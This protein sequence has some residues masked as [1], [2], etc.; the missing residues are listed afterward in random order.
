M[1]EAPEGLS[2]RRVMASAFCMPEPCALTP[3]W[4]E[5]ELP[6]AACVWLLLT[7]SP[8]PLIRACFLAVLEE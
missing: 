1:A 3:V 7:P 4:E 5:A 2:G 8:M 6:A